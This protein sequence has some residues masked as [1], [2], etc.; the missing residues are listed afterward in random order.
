MAI[1]FNAS[2]EIVIK[3]SWVRSTMPEQKVTGVFMKISSDKAVKLVGG[4]TKIAEIF[5]L[6]EM[7]MQGDVMKMRQVNEIA[8]EPAKSI[9]LKPGSYHIMLI[10]LKQPVKE[11]SQVDLNLE[12]IDESGKKQ[13]V[14]VKARASVTGEAN[15]S[16]HKHHN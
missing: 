13:I 6:H 7:S 12:F 1:S 16:D 2:A 10:N 9:E 5:Q 11:G 8:V 15:P 14:K 3:D 4:N